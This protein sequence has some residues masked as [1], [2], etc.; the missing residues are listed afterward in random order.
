VPQNNGKYRQGVSRSHVTGQGTQSFNGM[1]NN[2][3]LYDMTASQQKLFKV[4]VE[5]ANKFEF[6]RR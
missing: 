3:V 5:K 2:D 4:Q 6:E 1:I